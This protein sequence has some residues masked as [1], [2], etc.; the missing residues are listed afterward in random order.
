M[1][2]KIR[3]VVDVKYMASKKSTRAVEH[4]MKY[5][6]Y[7]S[8]MVL[9]CRTRDLCFGISFLNLDRILCVF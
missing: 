1:Q 8:V 3:K 9:N 5:K 4:K 6:R 2:T 7:T